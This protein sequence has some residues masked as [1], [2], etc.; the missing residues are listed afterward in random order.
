METQ[1]LNELHVQTKKSHVDVETKVNSVH[2]GTSGDTQNVETN[3]VEQSPHVETPLVLH[4]AMTGD[5]TLPADTNAVVQ[6]STVSS[7]DLNKSDEN[8]PAPAPLQQEKCD[9]PS[10]K[11]DLKIKLTPL[12]QLDIDVWCNKVTNYYQFTQPEPVPA[13]EENSGYTLRKCKSKADITAITLRMKG[14]IDYTPMMLSGVE[15]EDD[16]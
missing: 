15:E 7:V 11:K 13:A 12:K 10:I 5:T 8:L 14:N 2:V 16:E 1:R 6:T 4:V 9:K 3:S